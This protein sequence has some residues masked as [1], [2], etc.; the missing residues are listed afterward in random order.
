MA[1]WPPM[2]TKMMTQ[3][4][5]QTGDDIVFQIGNHEPHII[6]HVRSQVDFQGLRQ[7]GP[8]VVDN[9]FDFIGHP[10]DVFAAAL[11]YRNRDTFF[12]V[13]PAAG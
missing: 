9:A 5:N 6:G 12:P 4:Q 7:L 2:K 1:D 10:H 11:G 3:H 13:D 8:H